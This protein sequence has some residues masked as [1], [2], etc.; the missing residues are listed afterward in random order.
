MLPKFSYGSTRNPTAVVKK[1]E[2]GNLVMM[3]NSLARHLPSEPGCRKL[4][5]FG[6]A[7]C[8]LS[9][10]EPAGLSIQNGLIV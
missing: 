10:R 9:H 6:E 3:T 1:K 4:R 8:S 5:Q 7:P 2:K